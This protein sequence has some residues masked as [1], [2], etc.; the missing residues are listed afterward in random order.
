MDPFT[1]LEQ[2]DFFFLLCIQFTKQNKGKHP[3]FS[4]P[5]EVL[6]RPSSYL[7]LQGVADSKVA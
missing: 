3:N 5:A 1:L 2:A 4:R 7:L 6:R